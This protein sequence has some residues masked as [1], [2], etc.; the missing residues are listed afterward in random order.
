MQNDLAA[1]H[2]NAKKGRTFFHKVILKLKIY[3]SCT[4]GWVKLTLLIYGGKVD[5]NVKL[6]ITFRPN[7][8]WKELLQ[9]QITYC[10]HAKY[11]MTE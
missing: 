9:L 10:S 2:L 1:F 11:Y 8:D 4:V 5:P 3:E 7:M 6:G